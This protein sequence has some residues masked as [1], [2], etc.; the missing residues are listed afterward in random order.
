MSK[1]RTGGDKIYPPILAVDFD[2]TLTKEDDYKYFNEH[3]K[4]ENLIKE[5]AREVLQELHKKGC[6]IILW[7]CR[8][9]GDG[10]EEALEFCA[11]NNIPIDAVNENHPDMCFPCRKISASY[12]IDDRS[13]D[14]CDKT[15]NW[16]EIKQWILRD[17]YFV[18]K[19]EQHE[20]PFDAADVTWSK[21]TISFS[22]AD[23]NVEAD[24]DE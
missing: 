6:F 5:G 1:R 10:L 11:V 21:S 23:D 2:G 19:E 15:I 16:Y 17:S 3:Y 24:S 12:Y 8:E 13:F 18:D 9:Y 4:N 14:K 7:T 22:Y 20:K